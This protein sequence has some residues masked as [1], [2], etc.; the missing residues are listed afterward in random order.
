MFLRLL[1]TDHLRQVWQ[2]GL[3]TLG[4]RFEETHGFVALAELGLG[5]GPQAEVEAGLVPVPDGGD[6]GRVLGCL[7]LEVD[8]GDLLVELDGGVAFLLGVEIEL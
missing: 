2:G 5:L 8:D 6:E 3:G 1:V 4:P 7:L